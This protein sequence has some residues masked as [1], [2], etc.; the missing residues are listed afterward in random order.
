MREH[1]WIIQSCD[2]D[3]RAMDS[4][5][6]QKMG[7]LVECMTSA[8]KPDYKKRKSRLGYFYPNCSSILSISEKSQGHAI[9][10]ATLVVESPCLNSLL[11]R[12]LSF[13]VMFSIALLP[14]VNKSPNRLIVFQKILG[15]SEVSAKKTLDATL[16]ASPSNV[17]Q[18]AA[19]ARRD[20][21]QHV[22]SREA[23]TFR[24]TI[25]HSL[26][27]DN[28][29]PVKTAI[30]C[31]C[32]VTLNPFP[33]HGCFQSRMRCQVRN[34]CK[35]KQSFYSSNH[36]HFS[37]PGQQSVAERQYFNAIEHHAKRQGGVCQ[38]TKDVTPSC[39]PYCQRLDSS[40]N[41]QV[42]VSESAQADLRST[43]HSAKSFKRLCP[44]G[45]VA[46][47]TGKRLRNAA[48]G[49]EHS[50]HR[51]GYSTQFTSTQSTACQSP[52]PLTTSSARFRKVLSQT[53]RLAANQCPRIVRHATTPDGTNLLLLLVLLR[54]IDSQAIHALPIR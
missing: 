21:A 49:C 12:K 11:T 18:L 41:A 4:R 43:P 27:S 19:A 2:G 28:G 22:A 23:A 17:Q 45:N 10:Y 50:V 34:C 5:Q 35:C 14:E 13:V 24:E 31:C 42:I 3:R 30:R 40:A 9:T 38:A 25:E 15:L 39:P 6:C 33:S 52:K 8:S 37:T 36:T 29:G 54:L 16:P 20:H 48:R 32:A 26:T 44:S 51:Q 1:L 46:W 47:E 7:W 53:R